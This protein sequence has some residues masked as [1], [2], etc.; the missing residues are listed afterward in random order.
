MNEPLTP[1]EVSLACYEG[2]LAVLVT[3]I[4][5][6]RVSIW[7]IPLS[8]IT[9]RFLQYVD[10]VT[11]MNLRIAEDFI[12]MASLLLFIKSKMLLPSGDETDED[13]E[14]QLVERIMEYEQIRYM[15]RAVDSLPMVGRDVFCRGLTSINQETGYDL[16]ELSHLFF[17]LM[18]AREERFIEIKEVR[19][20]L[21]E[22][23]RS[24]REV[25]EVSGRYVWTIS[26]DEEHN[27]KVA[28]IL[29]MLELTKIKVATL[30]Q[31]RPFGKVILLK[32]GF[33]SRA[34][35]LPVPAGL[36][37]ETPS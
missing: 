27:E 22:R 30:W 10:L 33:R 28:T 24:L 2:P 29:G 23:I 9:E 32:R 11:E 1:L 14:E 15:A 17:E 12:D 16:L 4:R 19:P 25:L 6:N 13:V 26:G 34:G 3:L 18:R 21:E 5:K 8:T 31:G 35:Y 7:D 37:E 36:P 20:T